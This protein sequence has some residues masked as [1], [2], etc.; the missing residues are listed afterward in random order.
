ME[1]RKNKQMSRHK[2]RK[3]ILML[4]TLFANEL[5][6]NQVKIEQRMKIRLFIY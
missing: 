1:T 5:T 4:V 3:K 6:Q 2:V